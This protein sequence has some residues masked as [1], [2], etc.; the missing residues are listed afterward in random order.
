MFKITNRV[1]AISDHFPICTSATCNF[2]SNKQSAH[3]E[4]VVKPMVLN[5]L[6]NK[7]ATNCYSTRIQLRWKSTGQLQKY[8]NKRKKIKVHDGTMMITSEFENMKNKN[9]EAFLD[10]VSEKV[11]LHC[12]YLI[13]LKLSNFRPV[14][15]NNNY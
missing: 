4:N 7:K 14:L 15:F 12:K 9:R 3:T 13:I 1:V 6:L 5:S 8:F 10:M 11:I 2:F